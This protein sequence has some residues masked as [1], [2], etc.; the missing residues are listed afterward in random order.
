MHR[1]R[2]GILATGSIAHQFAQSVHDQPDAELFAVASR[3]Q[4]S[5]DAFG[6]RWHIPRRYASYEALANDPDVDIIYIATPHNLHYDNLTMCLEAGKHVLCEKPLTVNADEARRAIALARERGLFLM[7]ALWTR[8]IPAV[9]TAFE[10][11]RAGKIGDVRLVHAHFSWPIPY[12]PQAR[13]YAPELAGGALLDMGIYPLTIAYLA[14]G[15]PDQI[16]S[17]AHLGETGVD[18]LNSAIWVY[19]RGAHAVLTSTQ[20]LYRPAEAFI[21]GTEGYIKLHH[22][23]LH[24]KTLTLQNSW[25]GPQQVFN[26]P[27]ES[28]GYI[29][30]VREVQECLRAG[31]LESDL[32]PLDES[33]DLMSL[34]DEMRAQWGVVYPQER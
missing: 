26:I 13:L 31:K 4:A 10:W 6:D 33:L 15:R 2:W 20:R 28:N 22:S 5:A 3:T 24:A 12:D 18:E 9:R 23:F 8:C 17:H 11:I 29:Y 32:V 1:Y 14:L 30:Q 25:D 19:D 21:S 27:Y 34:M 7:E 16:L